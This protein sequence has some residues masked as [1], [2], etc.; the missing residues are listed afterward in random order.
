MVA[1]IIC[2]S[3]LNVDD[4]MI[5]MNNLP[6]INFNSLIFVFFLG[7]GNMTLYESISESRLR[8]PLCQLIPFSHVRPILNVDVQ[9]LVKMNLSMI[10]GSI[11]LPNDKKNVLDAMQNETK[12]TITSN[13]WGKRFKN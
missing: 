3:L 13:L 5:R 8:I 2:K 1:F 11:S 4:T 10:I 6:N 12:Q 7:G 9:L